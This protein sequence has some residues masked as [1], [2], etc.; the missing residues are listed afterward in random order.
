MEILPKL[1]PN[2]LDVELRQEPG[3]YLEVEPITSKTG[4]LKISGK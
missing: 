2:Y 1:P 4:Q 3:N